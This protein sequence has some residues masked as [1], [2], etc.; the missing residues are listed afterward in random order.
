MKERVRG[1]LKYSLLLAASLLGALL[2][3]GLV[4]VFDW[5]RWVG[6][7]LVLML[8]AFVLAGRYLQKIWL[9]RR[10]RNFVAEV[11]DRDLARIPVLSEGE[12]GELKRLQE[13]WKQAVGTVRGSHL[14]K[15]G[16]PLYVL[17][18][19][20]LIGES[21]SG[22]TTSLSSARLASPLGDPGPVAGG[23]GTKQCDWWFFDEAV[24]IDTAGRYA[25]PVNEARDRGEWQRFLALMV[26]Y[27]RREPL[28]GVIVT[29]AAD[30]LL[31]GGDEE[32][33]K[34]GCALRRRVDELMRAT[35]IRVPVYLLVTK[36]DLI[37]GMQRFCACL[38]AKSLDQPMGVVNREL[39]PEVGAFVEQALDTLDERLRALRLQLLHR[40]LGTGGDP[41]LAFFP[42][43]FGCLRPGLASFAAHAFGANPYQE[44]PLLRGIFFGSGRQ[45]GTPRSRF[46]GA[47]SPAE[48]E[49][50]PGTGQGLFL[51]DLF[52]ETL[53]RDRTSLTPTR[54]SIEWRTLTGHLGL[55]SWVVLWVALSG[56]LSFSFVKNLQ[57]IR[58][59]SHG[60]SRSVP[61]RGDLP[62]E[63]A[64]LERFREEIVKVEEQ[65]RGWWLPRFGLRESLEVEKGLK[66]RFCR[67]FR[68][69][70]LT[71]FD[72]QLAA[73]LAGVSTA[74][75]D[76][77]YGRYTLHLVRRIN[78][79]QA[80]LRDNSPGA[81]QAKPHPEY[82][83]PTETPVGDRITDGKTFAVLQLAALSWREDDAEI[84]RE[85]ARLQARLRQLIA[86]RG[87]SLQW[88]TPWVDRRGGIAPVTLKEFWGGSLTA[89]GE[90]CVPPSCTRKGRE[91][92]DALIGELEEALPDRSVLAGGK[93]A[94]SPWYR[95]AAFEAW[96]AFA[97]EFP[98]GEERLLTAA[99]WRQA[100]LAMASDQGPYFAFLNR[101]AL[102]LEPLAGEAPLPS[103]LQQ[104]YRWQVAR[105]EGLALGGSAI[106]KA[107]EGGKKILTTIRKN[108]GQTAG[109]QRLEARA[110]TAKACRD[111]GLAL[112]AITPAAT[113]RGQLF[114]LASQTF[115]ED[116][117]TGKSPL[118]AAAASAA[119]VKAGLS[120]P[121]LD[122]V[123]GR[124]LQ[125]PLEF[126]WRY[127]QKESAAQLQA[128]WE[129]QVLAA[130][131][132][133]GSQQAI[134]A[135][136]GPDGLA[137][138]FVKG[139]AAPFLTRGLAGYRAKETLGGKIA[140][141]GA[142]FAFLEKGA[143]AQAMVLASGRP[144][145][146]TVGVRALPTDANAEAR[147]KPQT[148]RLE[149]QCGG[150][151]QSVVNNNYPVGKTIAWSPDACGDVQFQ[152][153]VG[154]VVLTRHYL[155]P[156]G[157][158]E[159]LKD[160]RGGRRMF[161]AREFP[162][163]RDALER[164]GVKNIT[165]NYQ[166]VGGGAILQQSAALSGQAPRAIARGWA[167]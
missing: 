136:L 160:M 107:A 56:L 26:K 138:R 152:I 58:E 60:I 35:G 61:V 11:C 43:E 141:E 129:E 101:V 126:L 27:R 133:M 18:W 9:G 87:G 84:A 39:S 116:E 106:D 65:N 83:F 157:F 85:A 162:G 93:A 36:C 82:L 33:A 4:L 155:G 31:E 46:A 6:L 113:S 122:P 37:A 163:E 144:Q 102:E 24:V 44:T 91:A 79:L 164:I 149:I 25:L 51:H 119:R 104:L 127:L 47:S 111:Y 115:G 156:Q 23:A 75:P 95:D 63:L 80:R 96:R 150:T 151:V 105:G 1:Y 12:Q 28:N 76:E 17:P 121:A 109:A 20:L 54:R 165:V 145:N 161:S 78:L 57:T 2:I 66:E 53:P 45:Q 19:Y 67:D 34:D 166:F 48:G 92:L 148:T 52:A 89:T 120:E 21:G 167:R 5:P 132:G 125:G 55:A 42:E 131:V 94:F 146:Y 41:G 3:A 8:A 134:P 99:E 32:L 143:R 124:L 108:V 117:A 153:E 159:F 98:R 135:L 139:P 62:A 142:L 72:R 118:Y 68:E 71:P 123:L 140:F 13:R 49:P 103:W 130:V 110:A 38:P 147:V 86:V 30:R 128:L 100:A 74:T 158:P 14:G 59:F 77:L 88:L 16:N 22:K 7:S 97:A 154:D 10:E 70:L 114:Q 64:Q 40:P 90:R 69:R 29:V 112:C 50:L 73:A 81:L 15:R 137:W